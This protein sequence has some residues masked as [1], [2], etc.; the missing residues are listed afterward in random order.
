MLIL[1]LYIFL[2]YYMSVNFKFC[3]VVLIL[4]LCIYRVLYVC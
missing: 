1:N 3:I 2:E 4:S